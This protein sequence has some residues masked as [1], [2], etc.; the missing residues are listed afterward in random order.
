MG[1]VK[2]AYSPDWGSADQDLF[3]LLLDLQNKVFVFPAPSDTAAVHLQ[4]SKQQ[5]LTKLTVCLR[6]YTLLSRAYGLFSYATR[7]SDNDFLIYKNQANV[8][9]IYVGNS[10]V[11]F[12]V[13][14]KEKP[15]W[16]HICVSWDSSNG[17]VQFWLNGEP[18]PRQS[19]KKGHSIGQEASIVLGQDQDS[20]GG[21]FE[22]AQ[23]F[24][25]E[26]TEVKMWPRVLSLVEIR[27]VMDNIEPHGPLIYWRSL[28]YTLKNEVFVEDFLCSQGVCT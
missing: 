22:S 19:V 26:M 10:F 3:C 18:F 5:P 12:K 2:L 28:N 11:N 20:F 16:D 8:Y 17:L 27:M 1:H 9:A 15:S 14:L 4:V 24:V 7:S 13:P 23:S 21:G 25:G 6:Y